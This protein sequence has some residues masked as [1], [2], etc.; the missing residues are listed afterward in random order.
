MILLLHNR[1]RT[2][3]GEE[4]AV[5]DLL[6][7]VREHLGEDAELLTRDS[8]VLGR[9]RAA[10][11][12]L[13]GGA[14]EDDV[15]VA[16]RRTGARVVHAHNLLRREAAAEQPGRRAGAA[17]RGAVAGH[18]LRVLAEA[19]AH[20]PQQI[21]DRPLLAA[22]RP[23]AVVQE[24]DHARIISARESRFATRASSPSA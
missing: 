6:W 7:L 2:T 5:E 21:L 14:D 19:L 13:R 17:D 15:A 9:A 11:A 12:L 23:V 10:T 3:G 18:G 24:Q 1:Y 16:V 4:R 22:R 20:E 8:A